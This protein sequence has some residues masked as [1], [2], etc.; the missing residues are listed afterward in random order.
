LQA[1]RVAQ[2]SGIG[3]DGVGACVTF[4]HTLI[5]TLL[6][7]ANNRVKKLLTDL[8]RRNLIAPERKGPGARWRVVSQK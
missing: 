3:P 6:L 4:S 8:S 2:Q 5:F 7:W 1:A